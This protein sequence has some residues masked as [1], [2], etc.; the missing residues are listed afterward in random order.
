MPVLPKCNRPKKKNDLWYYFDYFLVSFKEQS[1]RITNL[2]NQ[3]EQSKSQISTLSNQ[4]HQLKEEIA[5]KTKQTD[6]YT[7]LIDSFK[8]ENSELKKSEA[9]LTEK[10]NL[11]QVINPK[12]YYP[13]TF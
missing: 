13:F 11:L 9:I 8:N 5:S 3:L 4:V 12:P 10:A 7:Q 1:Q 2:E 6:Q